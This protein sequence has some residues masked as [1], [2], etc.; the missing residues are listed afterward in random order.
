MKTRGIPR[1]SPLPATDARSLLIEHPFTQQKVAFNSTTLLIAAC[2]PTKRYTMM[3]SAPLSMFGAENLTG[4][5]SVGVNM[6]LRESS[7]P[8][9]Q[10]C[11]LR[12][13]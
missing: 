9:L 5:C 12:R 4:I 7:K 2:I 3:N 6:D 10:L 11:S 13:Q 1:R 8:K